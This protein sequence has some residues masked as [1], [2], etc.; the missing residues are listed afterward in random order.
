MMRSDAGGDAE[1]RGKMHPGQAGHSGQM[2]Q[3]SGVGEMQLT[4]ARYAD[5]P[6]LLQSGGL[7]PTMSQIRGFEVHAWLLYGAKLSVLQRRP[8]STL[9]RFAHTSVWVEA[10]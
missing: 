3:A 4:I 5:Q 8:N 7:Q 9:G 10:R 6:P 2:L 1:L